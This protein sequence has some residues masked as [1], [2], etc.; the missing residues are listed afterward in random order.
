VSVPDQDVKLD[1]TMRL[2]GGGTAEQAATALRK[3]QGTFELPPYQWEAEI[4]DAQ[5]AGNPPAA[6]CGKAMTAQPGDTLIVMCERH[7]SDAEVTRL[8]T[9]LREAALRAVV[10]DGASAMAVMRAG[11]TQPGTAAHDI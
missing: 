3:W 1:V 8:K 10:I 11:D 9:Q 6:T 7:L 4:L 5:P 2:Y